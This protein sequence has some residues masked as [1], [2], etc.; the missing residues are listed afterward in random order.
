V[1]LRSIAGYCG[2]FAGNC[3]IL[4]DF[5]EYLKQIVSFPYLKREKKQKKREKNTKNIKKDK[6]KTCL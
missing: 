1:V 5:A 3:G 6:K 2:I 4:R